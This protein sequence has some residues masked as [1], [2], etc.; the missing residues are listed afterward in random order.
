MPW[1]V[2]DP[3][4]ARVQ[5]MAAYLSQVYS[6]TELCERFGIRRNTGYK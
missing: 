6:M 1:K 4:N 3:M 5:F 2:T